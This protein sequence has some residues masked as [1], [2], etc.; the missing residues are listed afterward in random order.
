MLMLNNGMTSMPSR[1]QFLEFQART[2]NDCNRPTYEPSHSWTQ[3]LDHPDRP[4]YCDHTDLLTGIKGL[5]WRAEDVL[6][7][8]VHKESQGDQE[9]LQSFE[10][11]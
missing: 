1:W 2:L 10:D 8:W 5:P 3:V 7:N 9:G 6:R 11:I 4:A